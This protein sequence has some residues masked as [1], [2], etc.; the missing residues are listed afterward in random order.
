VASH[1]GR[2]WPASIGGDAETTNPCVDPLSLSCFGPVNYR[3]LI[4]SMY[5]RLQRSGCCRHWFLILSCNAKLISRFLLSPLRQGRKQTKQASEGG[6]MYVRR[7]TLE[8]YL[9]RSTPNLGACICSLRG[10]CINLT[11]HLYL[12]A[13]G[14]A[15]GGDLI[16]N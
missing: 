14:R 15:G 3:V 8:N 10:V 1:K 11:G 2:Q 6:K 7:A 9:H 13:R 16:W 4:T 12:H 5:V